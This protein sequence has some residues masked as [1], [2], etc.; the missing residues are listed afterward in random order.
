MIYTKNQKFK[1]FKGI[2]YFCIKFV[3]SQCINVIKLLNFISTMQN[4][5]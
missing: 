4:I 3:D 5:F 2:A 1:I